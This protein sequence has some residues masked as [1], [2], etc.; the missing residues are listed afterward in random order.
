MDIPAKIRPILTTSTRA[1]T[2]RVIILML[3]AEVIALASIGFEMLHRPTDAPGAQQA[4]GSS[5]T[6]KV[7][8]TNR[9][10]SVSLL[11]FFEHNAIQYQP[12]RHKLITNVATQNIILFKWSYSNLFNII[13]IIEQMA[14]KEYLDL[15]CG[16]S[17]HKLSTSYPHHSSFGNCLDLG[18]QNKLLSALKVSR[19]N[20]NRLDTR[21]GDYS[22]S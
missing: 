11:R 3:L 13:N 16:D 8:S 6:G 14:S 18:L 21:V 2:W 4:P 1:W 7:N 12:G 22:L 10:G 9:G 20:R 19:A 15:R 17:I 5:Q